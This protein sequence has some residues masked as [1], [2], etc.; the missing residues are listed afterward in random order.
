MGVGGLATLIACVIVLHH[1]LQIKDASLLASWQ[2]ILAT[3][4][5]WTVS[6]CCLAI[7]YFKNFRLAGR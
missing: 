3:A 1:L 7:F 6:I 2:S 4:A 5:P